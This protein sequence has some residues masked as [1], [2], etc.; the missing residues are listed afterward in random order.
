MDAIVLMPGEGE[1]IGGASAVTI[2]AT[3]EATAGSLYLGVVP[4]PAR[5]AHRRDR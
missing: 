1:R 3:G 4:A 5:A 2:K